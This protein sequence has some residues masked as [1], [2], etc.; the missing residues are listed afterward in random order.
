MGTF[1]FL[2]DL[3]VI[4]NRYKMFA[5]T[6]VVVAFGL[7][8]ILFSNKDQKMDAFVFVTGSGTAYADAPTGGGATDGTTGG[9]SNT[10]GNTSS[11]C[12][13][14]RGCTTSGGGDAHD[15]GDSGSDGTTGD[16]G[17]DSDGGADSGE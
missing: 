10:S 17:G 11:V 4:L 6:S 12:N 9:S 13:G 14:G 7:V 1:S 2:K 16:D 15:G 3:S 8:A 5:M